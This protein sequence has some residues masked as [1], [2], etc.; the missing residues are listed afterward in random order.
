MPSRR[1]AVLENNLL[2]PSM[3]PVVVLVPCPAVGV[4][5]GAG[6]AVLNEVVLAPAADRLQV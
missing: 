3:V 6:V 2:G 1:S 4:G 5:A